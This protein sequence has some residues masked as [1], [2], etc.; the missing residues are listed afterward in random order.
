LSHDFRPEQAKGF[1]KWLQCTQCGATK[2]F[3]YFW[4]GGYRSKVAPPC[5]RWGQDPEWRA[6]AQP[7]PTDDE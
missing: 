6:N 4:H 2:H 3:G 7:I 1:G 5:L